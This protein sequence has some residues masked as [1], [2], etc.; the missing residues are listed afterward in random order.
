MWAW[1]SADELDSVDPNEMDFCV[2]YKVYFLF[3]FFG[4][5]LTIYLKHTNIYN[6]YE[7]SSENL[8]SLILLLNQKKIERYYKFLILQTT[9]IIFFEFFKWVQLSKN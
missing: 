2:L 3:I 1:K 5:D 4:N 8:K 7:I 6:C 9:F